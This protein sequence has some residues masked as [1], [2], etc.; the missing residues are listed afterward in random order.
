MNKQNLIIYDF[1]ELFSILREIK[2]NLNFNLLNVSKKEFSELKLERIDY[3]AC[4]GKEVF[5]SF[6]DEN[7]LTYG[8]LRLRKPSQNAHR[9]EITD[10]TSIVRELHV[11]GKAIGIGEQEEISIQHQGIGKK[12]MMKAEE[13]ATT[14]LSSN[15][16]CVISAVGTREYY[17]KLGYKIN[18][19]YM[20]K[21][22]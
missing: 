21:E 9:Q 17:R 7:D 15:K 22:L 2:S 14:D 8:F 16:L 18:G 3:D 6:N 20:A 4:G 19:P 5:L 11:F 1:N 12:L 10:K 13:I